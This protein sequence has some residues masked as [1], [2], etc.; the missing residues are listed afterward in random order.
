MGVSCRFGVVS[1][2]HIALPHTIWDN[3]TRFHLVEVSIAAFEQAIAHFA[4]LDLDFLLI[5]GDLTQHGE[6]ENHTWLIQRLAELPYPVYVVPGNHDVIH[7]DASDRTLGLD[8]FPRY[9]QKFGYDHG[10]RPYYCQTILPG[11]RLIGLNSIDFEADG[12]QM[13]S[14]HI[15]AAQWDW[16][17]DILAE[18]TDDLTIVMIHHNVIEH[19]PDQARHRMGRRYMLRHAPR[20]LNC[21]KDAGVPLILTGHLHVQDIVG[22]QGLYE[23]TTGSLVSYPHPYRLVTLQ[24]A[25]EGDLRVQVE[26]HWIRSAPEFPDLQHTSRE[27]MGDRSAGFMMRF[28]T[29][30]PLELEPGMAEKFVEDLRYF[31]ADIARGDRQFDFSHFPKEVRTY[32]QRFGAIDEYGNHTPIDNAT[33][34]TIG[35]R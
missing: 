22:W 27:W 29:N 35:R 15:H 25:E 7:R 3:P 2:L 18:P 28:L 14:G 21:L 33:I 30:P 12:Q 23:I 34:L 1:D 13:G 11:L 20:L 24:Q 17:E 5:P 10:D 6:R 8:E 4:Q 9:Y 19:L 32:L 31:W 16:L 26:S